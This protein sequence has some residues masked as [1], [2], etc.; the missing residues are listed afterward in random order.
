MLFVVLLL[1]LSTAAFAEEEIENGGQEPVVEIKET[2]PAE[3]YEPPPEMTEN[4]E[5][6][7]EIGVSVF[8]GETP[9]ESDGEDTVSE[10]ERSDGE[11]TVTEPEDQG[12]EETVTEPE[13]P[14]NEDIGSEPKGPDA[15]EQENENV[16]TPSDAEKNPEQ[17]E[18]NPEI[19]EDAPPMLLAAPPK[20]GGDDGTDETHVVTVSWEIENTAIDIS[21]SSSYVWN[22]ETLQYEKQNS[23]SAALGSRRTVGVSITISNQYGAAVDYVIT[24]NSD[25]AALENSE[26][27]DVSGNGQIEDGETLTYTG[28]VTVTGITNV[29]ALVEG[30]VI[31]LGSYSVTINSAESS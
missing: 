23:E 18:E 27:H 2:A 25:N 29:E 24:Y 16:A 31:T 28:T 17:P 4:T 14:D 12:N 7:E 26:T 30:A 19:P 8:E 9:E 20:N 15:S 11:E 5:G 22:T 3:D 13:E 10:P 21:S 6:N 1:S